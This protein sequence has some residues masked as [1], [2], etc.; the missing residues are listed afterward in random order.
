M[1]L[2]TI[3]LELVYIHSLDID[4]LQHETDVVGYPILPL[5]R[6]L[7]GWCGEDAGRY[8]L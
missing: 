1:L 5:V 8:V 6:Q 3:P 7:G 4:R 2:L